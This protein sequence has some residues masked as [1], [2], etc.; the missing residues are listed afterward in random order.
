MLIIT[1]HY[2]AMMR[3]DYTNPV[4]FMVRIKVTKCLTIHKQVD[5]IYILTYHKTMVHLAKSL[6][7]LDK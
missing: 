1:K 3:V 7:G 5:I 4:F 2:T 6:I